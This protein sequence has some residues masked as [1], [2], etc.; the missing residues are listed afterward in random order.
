MI[1]NHCDQR[2][3]SAIFSIRGPPSQA[4]GTL[5]PGLLARPAVS[6][7]GRVMVVVVTSPVLN[8]CI[9]LMRYAVTVATRQL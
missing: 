6:W 9:E 5:G 1:P 8:R 7:P 3:I 4:A 2:R